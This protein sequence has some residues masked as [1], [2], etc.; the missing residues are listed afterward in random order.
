MGDSEFSMKRGYKR[1]DRVGALLQQELSGL[2]QRSLKDPRTKGLTITAV[3]VSPDLRNAKVFFNNSLADVDACKAQEGLER[4]AGFLR[5]EIG[6]RL[7]LKHLPDLR[8]EYDASFDVGAHMDQV[9]SDL[10][11]NQGDAK[12]A[13]ESKEG[14]DDG[15]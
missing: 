5:R 2:I 15:R 12:P 6:K 3:D 14:E 1:A 11:E 10:P 8:F 7:D 9:I 13:G 4:A